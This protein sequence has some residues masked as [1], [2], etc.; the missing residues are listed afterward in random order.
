M[1]RRYAGPLMP[2]KRSAY[3]PGTST[4]TRRKV[5]A[6]KIQRF[7]RKRNVP[8]RLRVSTT[9]TAQ[10]RMVSRVLSN[11]S[12][13]KYAGFTGECLVPV[14][15]PSGL[16][17][18]KYLF[19]NTGHE[20]TA[21]PEFNHMSLFRFAQGDS[22]IQ[23]T[24]DYMYIKSTKINMEIQV[25]P[26]QGVSQGEDLQGVIEFRVMC[27]KAN[28]KYNPLSSFSDP[29]GSLF[30]TNVNGKFG[31]DSTVP[32]THQNFQ[33]PINK[34]QWLVYCDKRFSLSPPSID[35]SSIGGERI[36]SRVQNLKTKKYINL[37]LPCFK[38]CHF[39]NDTGVAVNTP[40]NFDSQWLIII[41][42]VR[43]SYCVDTTRVPDNWRVNM[44]AT[45][46]AS[47]V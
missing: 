19:Y 38:K 4:K 44:T 42:A 43:G 26:Q 37:S 30:L 32:T 36:Q 3:V 41:Q 40:D 7:W 46:V 35:A 12:E 28:R 10:T 45:T 1:V 16:Q 17:P 2:G 34:R 13:N 27:V 22:N 8:S 15:K 20:I 24:G 14:N 21:L 31:Y 18:I 9:R 29:G 47:D 23:R 25:L 5:A 39:N 33:Q 6:T 11:I